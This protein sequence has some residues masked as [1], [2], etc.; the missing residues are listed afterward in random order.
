MHFVAS[1]D[2][3]CLLVH[4]ELDES[5]HIKNLTCKME[6]TRFT[7]AGLSRD[8]VKLW[9]YYKKMKKH[10]KIDDALKKHFEEEDENEKDDSDDDKQEE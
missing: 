2:F 7:P 10:K 1:Y 9:D 8:M 6:D 5:D 3:P 4:N